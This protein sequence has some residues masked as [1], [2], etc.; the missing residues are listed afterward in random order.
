M[1]TLRFPPGSGPEFLL[2]AFVAIITVLA[3][4]Q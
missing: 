1:T 2:Y 3:R 4:L